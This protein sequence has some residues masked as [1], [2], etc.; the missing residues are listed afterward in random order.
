MMNLYV[1][2]FPFVILKMKIHKRKKCGLKMLNLCVSYFLLYRLDN[3][4]RGEKLHKKDISS[5]E[6]FR[7]LHV[8][9]FHSSASLCFYI[10]TK[11]YHNI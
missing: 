5:R 11:K 8:Y 9:S 10:K 4:R 2:K 3:F 1:S 6:N 7:P